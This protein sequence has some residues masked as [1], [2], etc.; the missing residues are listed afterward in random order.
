MDTAKKA[1]VM[2]AIKLIKEIKHIKTLGLG[3]GSTVKLF[4]E[5]I[6]KADLKIEDIVTASFD[7]SLKLQEV[8]IKSYETGLAR[9]VDVYV[10]SADEVDKNLNMIKGR[11]GALTR[12][13]VLAS[14]AK[15]RIFIVTE[16]KLVSK[17]GSTKPVPLEIV[18]FSINLVSKRLKELGYKFEVRFAKRKDGPEISDN[19]G[20]LIDVHTGPMDNPLETHYK[21]KEITG[22]IETGIFVNYV[23]VLIIGRKDR[24]VQVIKV[25]K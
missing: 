12:E 4:I 11:G 10:D 13:K 9:E 16:N 20:F 2:K 15:L 6:S 21:F 19:Y 8:G 18:P 24:T 5:E 23:D 7:T 3:C 22:V 25:K 1:A 14:L 17:L